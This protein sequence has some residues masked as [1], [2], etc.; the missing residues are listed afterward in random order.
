MFR[1][2]IRDVLLLMV[3]VALAVAW[4]ADHQR[5]A[6]R[7]EEHR[8]DFCELKYRYDKLSSSVFG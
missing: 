2:T 8:H 1:F 3:I 4:W 6:K 7:L 5:M